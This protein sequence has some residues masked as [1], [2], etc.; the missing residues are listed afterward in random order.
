MEHLELALGAAG[1]GEFQ[2]DVP[3]DFYIVS[4]RMAAIAGGPAGF[5]PA[6]AG[7]D[8]HD[9]GADRVVVRVHES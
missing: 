7:P 4:E 5:I 8:L 3:G 1:L 6:D 9:H 2:Y